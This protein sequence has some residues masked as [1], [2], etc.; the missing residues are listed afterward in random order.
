VGW[1]RVGPQAG[2]AQ[3]AGGDDG[4]RAV[5]GDGGA[6]EAQ[7]HRAARAGEAEE[8]KGVGGE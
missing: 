2:G 5:Q 7:L 4:L 6:R 1:Q 8:G 3:A